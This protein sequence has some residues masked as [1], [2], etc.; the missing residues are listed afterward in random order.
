VMNYSPDLDREVIDDAFKRAFKVWS[1]VTPLTFTQIYS[2][3]ADIMIMFGSQE[4][5]DGYPFDGKDGLLAHA[6]PP[7][8]GIQGD[9]HFDDDELWTLGTGLA[10]GR[11]DGY[12]WGATTANFDQDKKYGFCPNRGMIGGNSQGDPCVFP[13][14]FLGQSYSACTSQGRQ[15]VVAAR[16]FGHSLGLDHSS[17][18]EALMYPMYSYVQDFQLAPDDVQGIQYLYGRGS[19]LEPTA[20]VPV[21]TKQPQPTP[22]EAATTEEEEEEMTPKPTAE[23]IPVDPSRDACEE[24]NFDAITEINGEL[25]FFKDGKY[26]TYS[27]FWKSGIQ[28]AFSIADTWPGLPAVIDAAF[29]DVLTQR[30]FFFA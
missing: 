21:P 29:Q 9:A 4:H 13:F 7:G 1:D 19:G 17:V 15:D 30:G 28:G 20:P 18:R 3:E 23:P 22:T 2:G 11:S 24:K 8:R 14:T 16:E 5:G 12:R 27:S 6:F 25:H 10:D 26:W